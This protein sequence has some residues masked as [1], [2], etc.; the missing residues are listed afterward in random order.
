MGDARKGG[1]TFLKNTRV[2]KRGNGRVA[3][4]TLPSFHHL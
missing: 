3:E 2:A 1:R 4:A